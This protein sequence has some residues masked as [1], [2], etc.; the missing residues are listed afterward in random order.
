MTIENPIENQIAQKMKFDEWIEWEN[1]KHWE[2]VFQLIC[3][4]SVVLIKFP[5]DDGTFIIYE[6]N[7][8]ELEDNQAT[9]VHSMENPELVHVAIKLQLKNHAQYFYLHLN[10]FN[11]AEHLL[12]NCNKIVEQWNFV[13][14]K[15]KENKQEFFCYYLPID[16]NTPPTNSTTQ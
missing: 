14:T 3:I 11:G 2:Y 16:N 5:K 9:V 12:W 1:L 7:V 4:N 10:D 8:D 13:I 6:F 15:L